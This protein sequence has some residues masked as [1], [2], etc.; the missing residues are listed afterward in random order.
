[1][2]DK[3]EILASIFGCLDCKFKARET[4]TINFIIHM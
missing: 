1:M 3:I 4:V 2:T